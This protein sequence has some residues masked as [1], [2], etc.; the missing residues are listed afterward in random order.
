MAYPVL[1]DVKAYLSISATNTNDDSLLTSLLER[2]IAIFENLAQRTFLTVNEA[3]FF[4]STDK[5]VVRSDTLF[6]RDDDII[7]ISELLI[8]DV[9]VDSG[10]Y[11]IEDGYAIK[12]T[13]DCDESFLNGT[14][15][16]NIKVTGVWGYDSSVPSDVSQAIIRMT[17]YL[18]AQKDNAMELATTSAVAGALILPADFPK[19]VEKI[20]MFYRRVM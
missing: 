19:D 3:R 16:N 12:L 4:S 13:S 14:T 10:Q 8:D 1:A 17:A 20:A 5:E 6:L 2:A 11:Y 18:Y 15:H 9:V 7:S